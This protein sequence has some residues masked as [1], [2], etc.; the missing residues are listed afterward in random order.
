MQAERKFVQRRLRT[1]LLT[2]WGCS[3]G[4]LSVVLTFNCLVYVVLGPCAF[5][6]LTIS[7]A[8]NHHHHRRLRR[9]LRRRRLRRRRASV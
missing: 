9:R 1:F 3:V 4:L 2:P 8:P 5:Q 7:G 6:R